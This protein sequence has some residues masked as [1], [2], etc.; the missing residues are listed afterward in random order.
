[1]ILTG[2][3]ETSPAPLLNSS[4]II[5]EGQSPHACFHE[6][7]AV[8]G[9]LPLNILSAYYVCSFC[10]DTD[11]LFFIKLSAL[12]TPHS[13]LRIYYSILTAISQSKMGLFSS[14]QFSAT[15]CATTCEAIVKHY[16]DRLNQIAF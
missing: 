9:L 15:A 4:S 3:T 8:T 11:E 12:T 6:S 16:T 13:T 2:A 14:N 7:K 5:I 1:L 10:K